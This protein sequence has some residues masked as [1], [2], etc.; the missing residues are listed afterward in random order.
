MIAAALLTPEP[1][2]ISNVPD[3][4]DVARMLDVAR[5]FGAK[6]SRNAKAGTVVL[7]SPRISTARIDPVLAARIRA[8]FLFAG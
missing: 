4:D 6:V 1:V 7:E 2:E 3:I 8:S 5:S